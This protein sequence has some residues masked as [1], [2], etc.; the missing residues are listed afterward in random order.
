MGLWYRVAGLAFLGGSM[1]PRG[2]QNPIEPAKLGVPVLHGEHVDNFRDVYD[3]LTAAKAVVAVRDGAS[4][5]AAVR[6]LM[7]D[8]NELQRL[9]GAAHAC[10]DGLTGALER[11]LEELEPYLSALDHD[12]AAQRA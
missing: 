2:G 5:A 10:V 6:R 4:L 7:S 9:A 11:T 8:Q 1:A 3:A 12:H